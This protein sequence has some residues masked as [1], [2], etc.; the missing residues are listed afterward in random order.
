MSTGNALLL[1]SIMASFRA[2]FVAARAV[3]VARKIR[4]MDDVGF[5]RHLLYCSLGQCVA[6]AD[7]PDDQKLVLLNEVCL[8]HCLP[9]GVAVV[10]RVRHLGLR[11]VG[12]R[13]KSC[14]RQRCVTTLGKLFTPMCLCYQAV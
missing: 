2:G 13:F 3:D 12:R 6:A 14:S 7:P 1:N 5:P 11:S 9:T 4:D 8:L 10:Q